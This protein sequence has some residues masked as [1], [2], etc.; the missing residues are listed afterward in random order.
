MLVADPPPAPPVAPAIEG[1]PTG[2]DEREIP[3]AEEAAEEE[4]DEEEEEDEPT[5]GT[6]LRLRGSSEESSVRGSAMP[7]SG[8]SPVHSMT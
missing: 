3:E 4:D 2:D 1:A 5:M 8:H 7:P 6:V